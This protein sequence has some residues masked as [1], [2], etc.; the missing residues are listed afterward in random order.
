MRLSEFYILK[1]NLPN[2]RQKSNPRV[3]DHEQDFDLL[4]LSTTDNKKVCSWYWMRNTIET[5]IRKPGRAYVL[6]GF[7]L[8][9]RRS[10]D[11]YVF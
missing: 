4:I 5:A 6:C 8:P 3:A 11:W 1:D 7:F 9:F 2:Y 10:L